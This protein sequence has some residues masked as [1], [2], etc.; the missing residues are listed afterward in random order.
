MFGQKLFEGQAAAATTRS[1]QAIF[2]RLYG[3]V[4]SLGNAT[5]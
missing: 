5:W 4:T 2:F 3:T 1:L